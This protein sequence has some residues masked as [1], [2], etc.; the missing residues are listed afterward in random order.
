MH[1]VHGLLTLLSIAGLW[2]RSR[3]RSSRRLDEIYSPDLFMQRTIKMRSL[4]GGWTSI[5]SSI[6]LTC[7][8]LFPCGYH[9]LFSRPNL[10]STQMRT[11]LMFV[12]MS[13]TH[14][15]LLRE[16]TPLSLTFTATWC[17][18]REGLMINNGW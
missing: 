1:A 16:P 15:P 5:G 17:K 2:R 7:V 8:P 9:Q 14:T 18:V 13:Q 6:S 10:Q 12:V 11:S 3:R 4:P